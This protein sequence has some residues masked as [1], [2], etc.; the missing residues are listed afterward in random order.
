M[1]TKYTALPFGAKAKPPK[2]ALPPSTGNRVSLP[3]ATST[4]PGYDSAA[5]TYFIT[6]S[7]DPSGEKSIG[8]QLPPASTSNL[9]SPLRVLRSHTSRSVPLREV[10]L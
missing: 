2:L 1:E 3:V 9:V 4:S 6:S 5:D 7:F 10:L 8:D